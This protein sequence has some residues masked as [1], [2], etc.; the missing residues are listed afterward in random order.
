MPYDPVLFQALIDIEKNQA[1]VK[2][3]QPKELCP[4]APVQA[5]LSCKGVGGVCAQPF[6]PD[7]LPANK[8]L[9][10]PHEQAAMPV[11][12]ALEKAAK[13][14]QDSKG[15]EAFC[16]KVFGRLRSSPNGQPHA[17]KSNIKQ[18]SRGCY[19]ITKPKEWSCNAGVWQNVKDIFRISIEFDDLPKLYQGA[20]ALVQNIGVIGSTSRY[21][22]Y[23]GFSFGPIYRIKD[24]FAMPPLVGPEAEVEVLY[25]DYQVI[26]GVRGP[27]PFGIEKPYLIE[28]QLHVQSMIKQKHDGGHALYKKIRVLPLDQKNRLI[29]LVEESNQLYGQGFQANQSKGLNADIDYIDPDLVKTIGAMNISPGLLVKN[30]EKIL[31]KVYK[32]R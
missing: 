4:G 11:F 2:A 32:G 1:Q 18:M 26:L 29:A 23:E 20:K 24:R 13:K 5:F 8:D 19:K 21:V 22:S 25:K 9:W 14:V 15:Y 6:N 12:L 17:L 31:E 10:C 7:R 16:E 27:F 30:W 28:L 3:Q